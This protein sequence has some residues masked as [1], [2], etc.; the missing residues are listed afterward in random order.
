MSFKTLIALMLLVCC[1]SARAEP[2]A[3]ERGTAITDPGVLRELDRGRLSLAHILAPERSG[4][5]PLIDSE[6]VALPAMLPVRNAIDSEF[7]RYIAAHK[8]ELPNASIGVGDD[9]DFQLFDR[10]QLYSGNAR[11]VL[12]GII[13]RM[14]RAYVTPD[15]CGE[16]RLIYRLIPTNLT[17]ASDSLASPR[18]PMTLIIVLNAKGVHATGAAAITCAEIPRRWLAAGDSAL[19]GP[20]LAERLVSK[21][22]PLDI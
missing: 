12:S 6:L 10:A 3:L 2:Q 5:T 21:D 17:Q 1:A 20:A 11:F 15:T 7:D 9:F 18:S 4:D 13:N 22:G 19:S 16:T 14:D 8:A